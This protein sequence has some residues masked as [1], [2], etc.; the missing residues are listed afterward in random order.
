MRSYASM[1]EQIRRIGSN[2]THP[3]GCFDPKE[4]LVVPGALQKCESD[5][6]ATSDRTLLALEGFELCLPPALR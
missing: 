4:A 2:C 6:S 5:L 3:K 1:C